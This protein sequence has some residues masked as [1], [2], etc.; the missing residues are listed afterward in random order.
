M[1]RK[2]KETPWSSESAMFNEFMRIAKKLGFICYPETCGHDLVM[3]A[4]PELKSELSQVRGLEPGDVIVVEGKLRASIEVLRQALPPGLRASESDSCADF[5]CV[6]VPTCDSDFSEVAG[7][8]GIVVLALPPAESGERARLKED[9]WLI[10]SSLSR[11]WSDQFRQPLGKICPMALPPVVVDQ[12]AGAPSPK[13]LTPWKLAAVQL[14]LDALA[15]ENKE[16]KSFEFKRK[17]IRTALWLQRGWLKAV[18]RES[19]PV[20]HVV[21]QLLDEPTRPDLVYPEIV[22]ALTK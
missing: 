9:E 11:I 6:L 14:C 21:Y 1:R 15:D 7:A 5:Y 13:S 12:E 2:E 18:R 16:I 20:R 17:N 3:V 19:K 4:G 10:R 22:R 8:C